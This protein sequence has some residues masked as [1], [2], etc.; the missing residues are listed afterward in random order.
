MDIAHAQ[1]PLRAVSLGLLK[2]TPQ[3]GKIAK[4]RLLHEEGCLG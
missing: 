2:A 1:F 4:S 3:T